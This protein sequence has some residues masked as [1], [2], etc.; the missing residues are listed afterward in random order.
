MHNL[1]LHA[2]A[3]QIKK[4]GSVPKTPT[5]QG[6]TEGS[7]TNNPASVDSAH[8]RETFGTNRDPLLNTDRWGRRQD[9]SGPYL[10]PRRPSNIRQNVRT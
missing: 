4:P 9:S 7:R 2:D 5:G 10:I 1:K 6:R 3:T 8:E